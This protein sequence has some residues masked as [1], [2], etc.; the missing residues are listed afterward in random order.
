MGMDVYGKKPSDKTGEYF[1]NTVWW[2]HPLAEYVCTVAPDITAQCQYWQSNDGDGLD[3]DDARK[4]AVCLEAE[5]T[6]GQTAA[7]AARYNQHLD[8]LPD[9]P[10]AI[11]GGTGHRP[12]PPEIGPGDQPCNGCN[13]TGTVQPSETHYPFSVENVSEFAAFLRA[14]GGFEIC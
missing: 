7:Y 13:S 14:C 11:C 1:R 3:E 2:W 10:C 9:E 12:P 5:I 6:T 4:L 8:S